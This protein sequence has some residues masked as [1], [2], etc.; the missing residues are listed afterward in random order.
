MFSSFVYVYDMNWNFKCKVSVL[1]ET[2]KFKEKKL[3]ASKNF[4]I[5]V[6]AHFVTRDLQ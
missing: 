2:A 3:E 6:I 1:L 5:V 4:D